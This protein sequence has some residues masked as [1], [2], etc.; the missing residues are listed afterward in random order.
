MR[1]TI[2]WLLAQHPQAGMQLTENAYPNIG[3]QVWELGMAVHDSNRQLAYALGDEVESMILDGRMAAIYA[4]QGLRY[5]APD[6]YA[7]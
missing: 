7:Q 6:R 3:K 5:L 4:A 1:E 2:E